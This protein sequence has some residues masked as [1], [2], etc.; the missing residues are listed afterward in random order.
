MYQIWSSFLKHFRDYLSAVIRSLDLNK[1]RIM[2]NGMENTIG[3][4]RPLSTCKISCLLH[5]SHKTSRDSCN[6]QPMNNTGKHIAWDVLRSKQPKHVI[7]IDMAAQLF[8]CSE[9]AAQ[10]LSGDA[11]FTVLYATGTQYAIHALHAWNLYT[12][13]TF[14][15]HW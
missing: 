6:S 12:I 8:L 10:K 11:V 9:I 4:Y 2:L 14:K 13:P 1:I 3:E 15:N 5:H 7:L